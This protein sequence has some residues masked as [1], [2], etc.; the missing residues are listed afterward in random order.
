MSTLNS[1]YMNIAKC[2]KFAACIAL[3]FPVSILITLSQEKM[4]KFSDIKRASEFERL[5]E[6]EVG[7]AP[8][9]NY[10]LPKIPFSFVI[11]VLNKSNSEFF[12]ADPLLFLQ[13]RIDAPDGRSIDIPVSA[14]SSF[15]CSKP[16]VDKPSAPVVFQSA[17]LDGKPVTMERR[18]YSVEPGK[19]V[20]IRFRCEDEVGSLVIEALGKSK[21]KFVKIYFTLSLINLEAAT[22]SRVLRSEPLTLPV[23]KPSK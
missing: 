18:S 9:M 14:M 8:D 23:P 3:L 10:D 11:S 1:L 13:M 20:D 6:V 21:E 5:E 17:E 12:M 16:H 19:S 15:I 22:A 2:R 4:H 7:I